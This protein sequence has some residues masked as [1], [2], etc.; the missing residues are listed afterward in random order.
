MSI[1]YDQSMTNLWTCLV[2]IINELLTDA[3]AV[4]TIELNW[5]VIYL[6]TVFGL[7]YKILTFLNCKNINNISA[8]SIFICTAYVFEYL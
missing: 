6:I 5:I 7:L 8:L 3:T 2:I 1:I 4:H